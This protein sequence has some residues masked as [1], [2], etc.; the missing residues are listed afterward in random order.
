[1]KKVP[2]V[3][4]DYSKHSYH[5]DDYDAL[6]SNTSIIEDSNMEDAVDRVSMALEKI[7]R[8]K[9]SLIECDSTRN[10]ASSSI[11][12]P[13]EDSIVEEL[14]VECLYPSILY[15]LARGLECKTHY[16]R[17]LTKFK[18]SFLNRNAVD[19][20]MRDGWVGSIGEAEEILNYFLKMNWIVPASTKVGY[21]SVQYGMKQ[22]F[23]FNRKVVRR[24]PHA[25]KN[26][27]QDDV[28]QVIAHV[29][30]AVGNSRMMEGE[31][32]GQQVVD[33]LLELYIVYTK[34]EGVLLGQWLMDGHYLQS[35]EDIHT[36]QNNV[37]YKIYC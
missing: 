5:S 3:D 7:Q 10:T 17:A 25:S 1:M 14:G 21:D 26:Y 11:S 19:V 24:V 36:L 18:S 27:K 34:E 31:L 2:Y 22:Y 37:G 33:L 16:N 4:L 6:L 30:C 12:L 15:C 32:T 28:L 35:L 29:L 23:Q 13:S 20:L 9:R 8:L